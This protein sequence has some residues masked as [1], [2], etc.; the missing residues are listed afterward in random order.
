MGASM[1]MNIAVVGT[2]HIGPRHAKSVVGCEDTNLLCIVDPAPQ[3]KVVAESFNVPL[4]SSTQQMLDSELK[5]DA[6]IVCTPNKSHVSVSKELLAAG[7]HVLVE[8]PISTTISDGHDLLRAAESNGTLL[9]VGH[10]RRFN[11]FAT[12]T[13]QALEGGLIGRPIAVTGMWATC[14]PSTYFEAPAE[15]RATAESGKHFSD[16][17]EI[18]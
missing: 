14:K 6:A 3:A 4:F 1:P 12:A 9:L 5:P 2:G 13:K 15:W 7:V 8:K 17:E 10:H 11:S 16:G 18:P